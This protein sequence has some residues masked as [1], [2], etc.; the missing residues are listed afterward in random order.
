MWQRKKWKNQINWIFM[1]I[2][3]SAD[4]QLKMLTVNVTS[5]T[6]SKL[7]T[8]EM[9]IFIKDFF[10]FCTSRYS[11]YQKRMSLSNLVSF[12]TRVDDY[13]IY[14]IY[15]LFINSKLQNSIEIFKFSVR[16]DNNII[17]KILKSS[18]FNERDW[19]EFWMIDF[20]SRENV[21]RTRVSLNCATKV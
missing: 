16:V 12:K 11:V 2:A 21:R 17:I 15:S 18:I 4:F 8:W 20:D 14:D 6:Y 10:Q 1:L 13:A 7:L 19:S 9:K 5:S 3:F